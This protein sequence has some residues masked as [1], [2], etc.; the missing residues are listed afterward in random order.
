MNKKYFKLFANCIPVRGY[1]N[2][3]I[4]DLQKGKYIPIPNELYDILL[5]CNSNLNISEI[6]KKYPKK[7]DKIGIELFLKN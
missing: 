1:S 2:S 6:K 4:C 5:L 3:I 7:D